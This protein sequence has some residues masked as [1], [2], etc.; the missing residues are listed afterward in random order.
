MAY[1]A[2]IIEPVTVIAPA[3]SRRTRASRG[4]SAGSRRALAA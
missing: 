3:K 2:S 4:W 1:T